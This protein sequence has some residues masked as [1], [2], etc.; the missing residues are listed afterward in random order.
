MTS[1]KQIYHEFMED[2]LLMQLAT[3]R[4]NK[5]WLCSVWYVMDEEENIYWLSR[6]ERRHSEEIAENPFAACTFHQWYEQ[7]FAHDKGQALTMSGHVDILMGEAC[8][9]PYQL[10]TQ[11]HPKMLD[12]QS[13]EDVQT[14]KGHHFMYKLTPE[15]I[16]WFDEINFPKQPRQ[17]IK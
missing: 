13:L 1:V 2:V 17:V 9:K 6:K 15:E 16:V 7:G 5:P 12:F 11:R 4:N 14:E 8:T 3:V 10:Y